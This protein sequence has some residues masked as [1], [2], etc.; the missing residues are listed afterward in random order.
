MSSPGLMM[1]DGGFKNTSGSSGSVIITNS[2]FEDFTSWAILVNGTAGGDVLVDNCVFNTPDG[3]LKTLGG[4]VVGDFTFT[5]NEMIGCQGHDGI[6]DKLVV[7]SSGPVICTGT[8][9]VE[10]NT[11]D[12]QAWTQQ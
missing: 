12:G 6:I 3:V 1:P 2:T 11:L 4:G 10:G 5:N 8:K 9:T 7:S